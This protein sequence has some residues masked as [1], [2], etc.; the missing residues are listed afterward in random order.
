MS[1]GAIIAPRHHFNVISTGASSIPKQTCSVRI[2]PFIYFS[3]SFDMSRL[4]ITL[5]IYRINVVLVSERDDILNFFV[6]I[7]TF[8]FSCLQ[9]I[10][11]SGFFFVL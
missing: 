11:K 5:W 2:R 3:V 7:L 8:L 6:N 9:N 10:C 4:I 1:T